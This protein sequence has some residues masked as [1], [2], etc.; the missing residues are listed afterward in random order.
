MNVSG[1]LLCS[2][3]VDGDLSEELGV[4]SEGWV[5]CLL[6]CI[7]VVRGEEHLTI[8]GCGFERRRIRNRLVRCC[9][10]C[11]GWTA[12]LRRGR[13]NAFASSGWLIIQAY[14]VDAM[15]LTLRVERSEAREAL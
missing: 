2:W 8:C 9:V 14:T 4:E 10:V 11:V 1:E 7:A 3:D 13:R 6:W 5:G 15:W 12:A